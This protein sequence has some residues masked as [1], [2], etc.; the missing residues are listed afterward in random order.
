MSL[1]S[2]KSFAGRLRGWRPGAIVTLDHIQ[3]YPRHALERACRATAQP[4]YLGDGVALGRVLGRYKAFF[5]T[6]DRGFASHLLLDGFWEIELTRFIAKRLRPGM[7]VA[8]VGANF[9]YYSLLMADLVG[10]QGHLLAIEPNPRAT[11]MLTRSLDLNGFAGRSTVLTA[12]A[13]AQAGEAFLFVPEGEPK[14]AKVVATQGNVATEP[15]RQSTPVVALDDVLARHPRVDFLKIDTEGSEELVIAGLGKTI[16]RCRPEI[17]LEFNPGR[18]QD[19][20][21]LLARLRASYPVLRVIDA[22]GIDTPAADAALLDQN[23][24]EDRLIFLSK[25]TS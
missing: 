23:D 24:E 17:V 22:Q 2:L 3:R 5:D 9:G 13:G 19:P 25:A 1:I 14:N 21:G 12:G 10:P 16:E 20:A 8:D 6:S 18:C 15:D 7:I 11:R 4:C